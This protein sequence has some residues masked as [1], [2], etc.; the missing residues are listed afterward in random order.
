M[1]LPNITNFT[2]NY[3][4][5]SHHTVYITLI[6]LLVIPHSFASLFNM[7]CILELPTFILALGSLNKNFRNDYLFASVFFATRI[8]LH[9]YIAV[10]YA[11]QALSPAGGS[12][13]PSMVLTVIFPM[14][15]MWMKDCVRGILRRRKQAKAKLAAAAATTSLLEPTRVRDIPVYLLARSSTRTAT[16]LRRSRQ[17]VL[18]MLHE[19]LEEGM[20]QAQAQTHLSSVDHTAVHQMPVELA[21]PA[22]AP[23]WRS[24]RRRV[25]G[26][27]RRAL[28]EYVP[29]YVGVPS[30]PAVEAAR[31]IGGEC[32]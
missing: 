18:R 15:A 14:H 29:P 30:A 1:H 23:R 25:V 2:L 3:A 19:A 11:R 17:H 28:P 5:C 27:L 7:C 16:L 22:A 10:S 24:I 26:R 8:C 12:W 21:G 31:P 6:T 32:E 9:I 13:A 4:F 20:S